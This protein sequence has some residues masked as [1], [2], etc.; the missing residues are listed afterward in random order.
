MDLL[1]AIQSIWIVLIFALSIYKLKWGISVYIAYFLLV[2]YLNISIGGFNLQWNLL[3]ML[4][5]LILLVRKKKNYKLEYT[6]L[7]PFVIY[8]V[9]SLFMIPFQDSTSAATQF[10]NWRLDAMKTMILP[11]VIWNT[12]KMDPSSLRLFRNT[13]LLCIAI[14]SGYGLFL[15]T[16]PGLNPYIM[17]LGD[18]NNVDF[19]DTYAE[20]TA[21]GRMF[22]RISSVFTHPMSY[23]LFL[24][25]A[26]IYI[27]SI[28]QK[29]YKIIFYVLFL[30]ILVNAFVCGVRS[31][32]G[33]LIIAGIVYFL[34]SKNL[35]LMLYT[36]AVGLLGLLIMLQI[37]EMD[38]Y[39]SSMTSKSSDDVGGSSLE[40]RMDQLM[41]CFTEITDNFLFGKGFG[42]TTVYMSIYEIHPVILCFESLIFVVLCNSGILGVFLWLY[43]IVKIM[44]YHTRY[45]IA[46]SSLLNAML[47]FY[48]GYSCITGEYGY[49]KVFIL[50]YIILLAEI[51]NRLRANK[52]FHMI[53]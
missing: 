6:P 39:L 45:C 51:D 24:G 25:L 43:I 50:F 12:Y 49:M 22:G 26:F 8:F 44:K 13:L 10:T 27:Y 20:A 53:G 40:L 4:I 9:V 38:T 31:V 34:L 35:K 15:T 14:A 7:I 32:L 33:G 46:D 36:A 1:V 16:M 29:I 3:N 18:L 52:D 48:L 5:L 47:F 2:P 11:F 21:G 17:L 30:I 41:G 37:P 42:W 28:K 19:N 23:G